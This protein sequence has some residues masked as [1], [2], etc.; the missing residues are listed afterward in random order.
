VFARRRKRAARERLRSVADAVGA[1][2]GRLVRETLTGGGLNGPLTLVVV[3]IRA[4]DDVQ[5]E[6]TR[7]LERATLLG[8]TNAV[9]LSPPHHGATLAKPR[10]LPMLGIAVHPPGSDIPAARSG[11]PAAQVPDDSVGVVI[12]VS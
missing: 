6:L 2:A 9:R 7:L 8:Y 5:R 1:R 11:E 4:G 10:T 12:T 3:S